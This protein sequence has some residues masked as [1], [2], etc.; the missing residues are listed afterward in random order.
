MNTTKTCRCGN[1]TVDGSAGFDV[2]NHCGVPT[3]YELHR[4]R[5]GT[6]LGPA[7]WNLLAV[8]YLHGDQTPW[9]EQAAR[10]LGQHVQNEVRKR[11]NQDHLPDTVLYDHRGI[12]WT[13]FDGQPYNGLDDLTEAFGYGRALVSTEYCD[14]PVW[15]LDTNLRFRIWHDTAHVVHQLG[16]GVDDEL[17]L[18]GRQARELGADTNG[19][20]NEESA[21]FCESVYQLAAYVTLGSYPDEQR[22]VELGPIGRGVFDLLIQVDSIR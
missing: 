9:A 18:F 17:Y 16:F 15:D 14:H 7:V 20:T 10:Y 21:L 11:W 2:C 12:S 8:E 4:E 22:V 13:P 19:P 5:Y 6:L 3:A 1:D